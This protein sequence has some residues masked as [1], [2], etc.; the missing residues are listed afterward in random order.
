M[1]EGNEPYEVGAP[2]K[3]EG[4]CLT[5]EAGRV[6][7]AQIWLEEPREEHSLGNTAADKIPQGPADGMTSSSYQPPRCWDY[8][9]T[10][11]HLV[12]T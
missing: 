7:Q 3:G 4:L 1:E 8:Q 9:C 5:E 12:L 6:T 11:A 10:P 2:Y